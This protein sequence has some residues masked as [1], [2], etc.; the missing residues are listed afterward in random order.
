MV[1][2][3]VVVAS[4]AAFSASS[5]TVGGIGAGSIGFDETTSFGAV[6]SA[7]ALSSS[8]LSAC[9]ARCVSQAAAYCAEVRGFPFSGSE[10]RQ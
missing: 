7:S 5:S 6:D 10:S 8:P 9:F 2:G 1:V 4:A 3:V